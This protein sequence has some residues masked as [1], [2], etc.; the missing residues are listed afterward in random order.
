MELGYPLMLINRCDFRHTAV[1]MDWNSLIK[2]S[3]WCAIS[4]MC[5]YGFLTGVAKTIFASRKG[6]TTHLDWDLAGRATCQLK[7]EHP[8]GV[9][10]R[11]LVPIP[12]TELL[13]RVG[14]DLLGPL[15]PTL[16]GLRYFVVVTDYYS[17]WVELNALAT[18]DCKNIIQF[19]FDEV[20]KVLDVQQHSW[21]WV[22]RTSLT[23]KICYY[24]CWSPFHL[25]FLLNGLLLDENCHSGRKRLQRKEAGDRWR[26]KWRL[27]GGHI[28]FQ[29][30]YPWVCTVKNCIHSRFVVHNHIVP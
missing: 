13:A 25:I 7:R 19:F 1:S 18:K 8:R 26:G 3:F 6:V 10:S 21:A 27:Y 12:I 28:R 23:Y 17:K 30:S 16:E 11:L 24:L 20:I 2:R 14:I 29:V 5:R 4:F 15:I 22:L 9:S